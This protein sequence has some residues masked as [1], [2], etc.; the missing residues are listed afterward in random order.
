MVVHLNHESPIISEGG[1]KGCEDFMATKLSQLL[2][3]RLKMIKDEESTPTVLNFMISEAFR[4]FFLS[5]IGDFHQFVTY[6][7][8]KTPIFQVCK[9]PPEPDVDP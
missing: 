3:E 7:S 4:K 1:C 2:L 8:D 9:A 6:A 5:L